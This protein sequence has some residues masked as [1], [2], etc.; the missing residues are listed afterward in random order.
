VHPVTNH[1]FVTGNRFGN[2]D[3]L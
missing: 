1:K 2:P 3:F